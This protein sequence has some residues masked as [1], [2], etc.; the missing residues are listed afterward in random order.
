[1]TQNA[2]HF[3][4]LADLFNQTLSQLLWEA[5]SHTLPLVRKARTHIR[6]LSELEQ[7]TVLKLALLTA[8]NLNQGP[9]RRDP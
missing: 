9:L 7:C 1:M 3:T 6:Q 8:Q 5:S 2:F 4:S